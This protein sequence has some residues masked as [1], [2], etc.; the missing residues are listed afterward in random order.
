MSLVRGA[1][2]CAVAAF[3]LSEHTVG[4]FLIKLTVVDVVVVVVGFIAFKRTGSSPAGNKNVAES[5]KHLGL[6][7]VAVDDNDIFFFLA[8]TGA[9]AVGT[10]TMA[11]D[12]FCCCCCGMGDDERGHCCC[13]SSSTAS[14]TTG[15]TTTAAV[16]VVIVVVVV[17]VVV[18]TWHSE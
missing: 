7:T 8:T 14:A 15:L 12:C 5:T 1:N 18:G 17:V 3:G 6:N 4:F 11:T 9:A 16:V 2:M 10:A 13:C